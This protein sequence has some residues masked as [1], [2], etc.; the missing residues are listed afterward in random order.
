M[1]M[2]EFLTRYAA[3]LLECLKDHSLRIDSFGWICDLC[4]LK[5]QCEKDSEENPCDC[6]TCGQYIKKSVTDGAEY[7]A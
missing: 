2:Q 5:E 4:P 7:K 6:T 1:D 3:N